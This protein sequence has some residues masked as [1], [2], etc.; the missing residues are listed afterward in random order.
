MGNHGPDVLADLRGPSR[1]LRR[2]IPE[3]YEGFGETCTARPWPT[4]S[5]MPRPKS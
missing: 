5:S 3:V 1:E 4:A 2:L